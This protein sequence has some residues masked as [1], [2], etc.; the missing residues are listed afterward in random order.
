MKIILDIVATTKLI[1]KKC[2]S[3]TL[4]RFQ[5]VFTSLNHPSQH[6]RIKSI[7]VYCIGKSINIGKQNFLKTKLPQSYS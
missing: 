2:F 1:A 6:I 5:I 4:L 3:N 7:A